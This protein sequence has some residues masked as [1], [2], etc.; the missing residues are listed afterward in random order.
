MEPTTAASQ[1]FSESV[2]IITSVKTEFARFFL[3]VCF[4]S[5]DK[6]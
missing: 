5:D 3:F 4:T 2:L 6:D 1:I